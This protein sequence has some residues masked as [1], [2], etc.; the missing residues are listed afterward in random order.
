M[1]INI[2]CD[3]ADGGWIYTKFI[4]KIGLY[5]KHTIFVNTKQKYDIEFFLPYYKI[6]NDLLRAPRTAWFS[7]Q[8]ILNPLKD[9][10][11]SASKKCDWCFSPSIKYTK[12]LQQNGVLGV[13]Q[14]HHGVDLKIFIPRSSIRP[15]SNKLIVGFVGR[16]YTS[17]SRKNERLLRKIAALD[18]IDFRITGGK[19]K[20]DKM[21]EFYTELDLICS[22]SLRE[23]GPLCIPE[24]LACG[25]PT[26]CYSDVGVADEFEHG[27][28]RV[29]Y[30]N[31][32]D[33][34]Q[35][36]KDFWANKEFNY[37][38]QTATQQLLRSQVETHTWQ[39]FTAAFDEIWDR[40]L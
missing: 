28:L 9:K 29:G 37:Y 13:S 11:I 26:L 22:P 40:L 35:R 6:N 32:Q 3:E 15:K 8:E 25:I 20:E 17:T 34:I 19:I 4:I 14:V 31:E 18:F 10:F 36:L 30:N 38:N 16:N 39:N 5:S 21:P 33:F 2:I 12:L 7:H 24:G 23:G 1:R 27:V